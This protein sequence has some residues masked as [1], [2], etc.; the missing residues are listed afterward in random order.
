[1]GDIIIEGKSLGLEGLALTKTFKKFEPLAESLKIKDP[2]K[3]WKEIEKALG[4][5]PK[6]EK[7]TKKD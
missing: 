2:E 3:A 4:R 1:M 6:K 7:K 5:E